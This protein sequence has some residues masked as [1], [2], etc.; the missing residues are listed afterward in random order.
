M[1]SRSR[2]AASVAY[3]IVGT[4]VLFSFLFMA[5]C[6]TPDTPTTV[7]FISTGSLPNGAVSVG[8][9]TYSAT[10]QAFGGLTPYSWVLTAVTNSNGVATVNVLPPGL[11]ISSSGT[12]TGKPTTA[13]TYSFTVQ[14]TDSG[15]LTNSATQ[16]ITINPALT[17][18][19]SGVTLV[20]P[21]IV[22]AAY[23]ATSLGVTGGAG[24][25]T[26]VVNSG[27]LPAGLSLTD[28]TGAWAV[29]G[30]IGST[31][32]PGSYIFT[33]Q[34][35]DAQGDSLI[36]GSITLTV[37]AAV[38][39]SAADGFSLNGGGGAC[40]SGNEAI[41]SGQYAFLVRGT[42]A[43]NG[44]SAVIGSF[45]AN[46]SGGITGGLM[47]VNGTTGPEAGLT[48]NST[49]SSYTMGADNRG[50]LT[51]VDSSGSTLTFHIA[52][53]MLSGTPAIATQG[54]ISASNENT[55]Q[56]FRGAGV[57]MQQSAS[58]FNLS[59]INGTY[60]FGR[61]G[62]DASGGRYAI[63]GLSTADGKG[64]LSNIRADYDDAFSGPATVSGGS[65]TYS[66]AANGR[67]TFTITTDGQTGNL[68][69]YVVSSSEL[70]SM[71][72]DFV[73]STHPLQSGEN[74]LQTAASFATYPPDGSE[75]AFYATGIDSSNGGGITYLGQATFTGTSGTATVTQDMNDEGV[76]EAE[77]NGP[78]LFT[79]A[80]SGR[81]IGT[82]A[83]LGNYPP[84][85]YLVDPTQ[86]FIVGTDN[87]VSSG[88]FQQQTG[89]PFSTSSFSGQAF[90][91]GSAP[92]AGSSY[93]SGTVSFVSSNGSAISN[94]TPVPYTFSATSSFMPT[95]AGQGLLGNN[96]LA[97]I[98]S[99]SPLKVI[100]MQLG[101]TAQN[102]NANPAE[103]YVGE[104]STFTVEPV[105][106]TALT[107]SR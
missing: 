87:F 10:L 71:S 50:C 85:V 19:A 57:L 99:V 76:E 35:T 103:L 69:A 9:G 95:A 11:S 1:P 97:Y 27:S 8:G 14:V 32:S 48:I 28:A 16:S 106:S 6:K 33:L 100:F 79:I 73:D 94:G 29:S 54:R 74:K 31:V 13:G 67:G 46:G 66:V 58:A 44:Y 41:L 37:K 12:I 98:V 21:G 62:I 80:P 65:G 84:I 63:A 7:F 88:Y 25:I 42:S 105:A 93:D 26:C 34:C 49:G 104:Q 43:S 40:G 15:G 17:V 75:Y 39:A 96:V 23:P 38:P 4:T 68:V 55:G 18:G 61:E 53:G 59:A 107:Q 102:T 51:L 78:A 72:T 24:S 47:D 83:G 82:G 20:N 81:M 3:K 52:V 2:F 30:N 89:G 77:T 36:S 22:G 45:A 86:G 101:A 56:E 92:G 70:L 60:A 91:G 5:G 64:N 90:F